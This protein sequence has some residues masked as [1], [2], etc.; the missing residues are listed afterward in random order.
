[1]N[2]KNAAALLNLL[3]SPCMYGSHTGQEYFKSD[4]TIKKYAINFNFEGHRFKFISK[5][6]SMD[7]A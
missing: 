2:N 1:M 3:K 4:R 5:N 6:P 7:L